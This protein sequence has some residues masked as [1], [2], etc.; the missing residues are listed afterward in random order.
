MKTGLTIVFLFFYS[1]VY[2]EIPESKAIHCLMGEARGEGL[3]GMTAVGEVLRKRGNT[4]GMYGC[5][6]KFREP[7]WVYSLAK[8]AWADS[9]SSSYSK[10]A[11]HFES[12]DFKRPSW[13]NKMLVVAKVGKHIFYKE[14]EIK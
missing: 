1:Q 4:N 9:R 10:G 8:R 13:S 6:A 7:E 11:T 5:K 12:S 2:A 14:R 3:I